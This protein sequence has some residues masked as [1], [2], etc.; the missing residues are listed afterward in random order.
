M[1]ETRQIGN[2]NIQFLGENARSLAN[3]FD[4]LYS[5]SPTFRSTV[6]EAASRYS[7]IYVGSSQADLQG[8]PGYFE[9]SPGRIQGAPGYGGPSDSG[10]DW[11]MVVTGQPHTL[12]LEGK[13]YEGSTQLTMAHEFAHPALDR[14]GSDENEF[15]AQ[16]REQ[17]IAKELGYTPG[18]NFPDVKDALTP[19]YVTP[20]CFAA[21]T[22]ILM[23]DGTERP[24]EAIK[25]GDIVIAFAETKN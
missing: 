15:R 25:P 1:A 6:D 8:Q 10:T 5:A 9:F 19:Y 3:E 16:E 11:F 24:I 4:G 14:L 7:N 12:N 23:A 18:E 2:T 21:G 20:Q 17:E 22:P 13:T